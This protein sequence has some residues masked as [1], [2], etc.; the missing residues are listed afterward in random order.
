MQINTDFHT[1]RSRHLR[2]QA[3]QVHPLVAQ[4]FRRRASEVELQA[5][6]TGVVSP[7]TVS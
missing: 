4:A 1:T 2:R 6:L 3:Q 7:T 5:W